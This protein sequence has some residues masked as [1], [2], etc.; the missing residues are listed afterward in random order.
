MKKVSGLLLFLFCVSVKIYSA[1]SLLRFPDIHAE[2]VVFTA[3][4]D[5]WL[6]TIHGAAPKRLTQGT[7]VESF[8]RFSPDGRYLAYTGHDSGE[9]QVYVIPVSGGAPRQLTFYPNDENRVLGW[10]P[11][12]RYVVFRSI[13]QSPWGYA[14]LG[15]FFKVPV[16][17]GAAEVFPLM[18]GGS[19][20]FNAQGTAIAFVREPLLWNS[21]RKRYR[22]GE[23]PDVWRY[24][25]A[26]QRLDR[27]I[28]SPGLD[29]QPIWH[30]QDVYFISERNEKA[31]LYR[32]NIDT[33]STVA[34]TKYQDWD[35]KWLESSADSLIFEKNGR[36][37]RVDLRDHQVY[38]IPIT[39]DLAPAE[40]VVDAR[41]TLEAVAVSPSGTDLAL[42]S[43]GEVFL[44][45]PVQPA[46]LRNLTRSPAARERDFVFSP[47][48]HSAAFISDRSGQDAIHIMSLENRQQRQLTPAT[49][50]AARK[51]LWSPDGKK[52]AFYNFSRQLLYVD[53]KTAKSVP[54]AKSTQGYIYRYSWSPDSRFLAY[55][56]AE[57]ASYFGIY[58]YDTVNKSTEKVT[59]AEFN[60]FDL[61]F[62]PKGRFLAF[63]SSR[64]FKPIVTTRLEWN[65]AVADPDR[66]YL[67]PMPHSSEQWRTQIKALPIARGSL[68]DL[69]VA[70]D[71]IVYRRRREADGIVDAS[72]WDDHAQSICVFNLSRQ[73]ESCF[74]DKS[75]HV[76]T[77]L[78]A[79]WVV[80][81]DTLRGITLDGEQVGQ[82]DSWSEV[83]LPRMPL[84]LNLHAEW[85]QMFFEAWRF[86]LANHHYRDT[87]GLLT[88]TGQRVNWL[89]LQKQYSSWLPRLANRNDLTFLLDEIAGELE[90]GHLGAEGGDLPTLPA[91]P[92]TGL[93]GVEWTTDSQ[94]YYRLGKI[95]TGENWHEEMRSPLTE[96]G[97]R[98]R[99]GDYLLAIDD[100]P[101]RVPDHPLRH[102]Q[103]KA[104]KSISLRLSAN[105]DTDSSWMIN[106]VPIE[107][108]RQLWYLEW[109]NRNKRRVAEATGGKVGYVHLADCM[110]A[111]LTSFARD[112]YGSIEK[113]AII[114]DER[115]NDGG[116]MAPVFI[117]RI[118]RSVE[119]LNF[120]HDYDGNHSYPIAAFA[121]Q[122][123]MLADKYA[124]SD[125]D[126]LPYF[127]QKHK[128]G[129][130]I[131][132]YTGG[133]VVGGSSLT[134]ADG[135]IVKTA[136][137]AVTDLQ[138]Y[139]E[140]ENVGVKPDIFVDNLPNQVAQGYDAQL[141]KA[142]E[143]L[144]KR[145]KS[146]EKH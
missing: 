90:I 100:K 99:V 114:V 32:Y 26:T 47:D 130:V 59:T 69:Q 23:A 106:V 44:Y 48:G 93:L 18:E 21:A 57:R 140:A 113:P 126:N 125:G 136:N 46:S 117:E 128:L 139:P 55:S 39:L 27:L 135:G 50:A 101:I 56:M 85:Q 31:N 131:G 6:S 70:G 58:L 80:N 143:V 37:F 36:L 60:D 2:Q 121:G 52:I 11:D 10:T 19:L 4:G 77:S 134:L 33:K 22:G 103:G 15:R 83:Q 13:Q 145:I 62:D 30:Q 81:K 43:R 78:K 102:L 7:G 109:V 42:V 68:S 105:N 116:L 51:P 75:A 98:A 71:A 8:A 54:V 111:G 141:E 29:D 72:Q 91:G 107:S 144:S 112:W 63:I 9:A 16:A 20:S 94:G 133:A 129:T 108:E 35:I 45:S 5:L 92:G 138:G 53:I 28:E 120:S 88:P 124:G 97:V 137:Q 34:V 118:R 82:M 132:T 41:T 104:G 49:D 79:I 3:G 38:A 64:D 24:D 122:T 76:A 146:N 25:F 89:A 12:G 74:E 66:V 14:G 96:A 87:G 17:G 40:R 61:A 65:F 127:Y 67:L 115:G 142:I 86:Q 84:Q 110:Q 1:E 123:A 73:Q 95:L 119:G